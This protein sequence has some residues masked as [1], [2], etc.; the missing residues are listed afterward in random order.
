MANTRIFIPFVLLSLIICGING[1]AVL[2]EIRTSLGGIIGTSFITRN[3]RNISAFL[4]IPYAQPPIGY[5]RFQNPLAALPWKGILVADKIAPPCPQIDDYGKFIGVE[6]CLFLNVYTPRIDVNTS[7]PTMVYLHGGAFQKGDARPSYL[8]PDF[9]L[10]KDVVLVTLHYR[11]GP[12]GF[13]STGDTSAPGNFGL[14]DQA[15]ALRW[16]QENIENFGGDPKSV[17]LFGHSAGSASVN[18]QVLSPTTKG[19]FHRFIAQSGSALSPW[20]FSPSN[21]YKEYAF[22][23]GQSLNCSTNSSELLIDCLRE[24]EPYILLSNKGVFSGVQELSGVTWVPTDEPDISGA[25]LTEHP[26]QYILQNKV[27]DLPNI[28]GVVKN[29]GLVVTAKLYANDTL[30]DEVVGDISHFLR[31]L[32]TVFSKDKD[33]DKVANALNDFYFKDIDSTNKSQV[34]SKLTDLIGDVSFT[35]PQLLQLQL[36]SERIKSPCYLYSFEYRG[37][38]SKTAFIL[39]NDRNIGITH[40]DE[41]IYLYPSSP[42][43]FNTTEAV[44]LSELDYRMIDVMI[45]MWTNFA[46]TGVPTTNYSD[47][48]H[49]W[50]PFWRENFYL[51]ISANMKNGISLSQRSELLEK[52][53]HFLALE[54][55]KLNFG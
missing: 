44:K 33:P 4:R 5:L 16:V 30:Y 26:L 55:I 38:Y 2:S 46:I 31:L 36:V 52:R 29:E 47:D 11:L 48:P 12:L 50:K 10:D 39:N 32:S 1:R 34:L 42:E 15:L 37:K 22:R 23:L 21:K 24:V 54:M 6:D 27:P 3:G 9:I 49:V 18:F 20:A 51:Q 41:L 19:L 14:K 28:N 8:G 7:Y 43:L 25:F 35:F 40:A 53:M 17:T 13:L 45:D